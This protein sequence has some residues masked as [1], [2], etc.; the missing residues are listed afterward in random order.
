MIILLIAF[1]YVTESD[2]VAEFFTAVIYT[3][4]YINFCFIRKYTVH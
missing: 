4:I 2:E 1:L 3:Y